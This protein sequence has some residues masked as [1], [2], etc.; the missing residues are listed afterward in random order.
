MRLKTVIIG[1]IFLLVVSLAT[2][3]PGMSDM[4]EVCFKHET[5]DTVKTNCKKI[6]GKHDAFS[7]FK[8]FDENKDLKDYKPGDGWKEID[9]DDPRC[10]PEPEGPDPL[11][12]EGEKNKDKGGQ[13]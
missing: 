10:Q 3:A 7:V 12:G 6:K 1:L 4:K 11:R 9:G 2:G 13:K 5:R 8:C